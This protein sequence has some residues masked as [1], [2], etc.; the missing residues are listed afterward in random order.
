MAKR[1]S[2]SVTTRDPRGDTGGKEEVLATHPLLLTPPAP[3]CSRTGSQPHQKARTRIPSSQ[4]LSRPTGI[5][6]R[7]KMCLS[8][9]G[10]DKSLL[11][12]P[13]GREPSVLPAHPAL[14]KTGKCL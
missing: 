4:T 12:A 2:K 8:Q 3:G 9:K 6:R 10:Q 1:D 7:K 5:R 14:E 11:S 13:A